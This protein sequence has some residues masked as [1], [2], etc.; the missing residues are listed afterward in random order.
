MAHSRL[1]YGKAAEPV[2]M[3]AILCA[4]L[5]SPIALLALALRSI[6]ISWRLCLIAAAVLPTTLLMLLRWRLREGDPWAIIATHVLSVMMFMSAIALSVPFFTSAR[7]P[8]LLGVSA[9]FVICGWVMQAG[10]RSSRRLQ[11][12]LHFE[13]TR[14]FAP[15][16]VRPIKTD[17]PS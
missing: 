14:G 9:A 11:R 3:L 1:I 16:N 8:A 17:G 15:V 2:M 10:L 4:I 13:K 7:M 6:P 5:G 12:E